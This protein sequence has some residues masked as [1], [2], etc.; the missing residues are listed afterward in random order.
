MKVLRNTLL[1][2]LVAVVANAS[3]VYLTEDVNANDVNV[4]AG[5]PVEKSGDKVVVSG[6]L[7]GKELFATKN[8]SLKIADVNNMGAVKKDG[9]KAKITFAAA[10][11]ILAEDYYDAWEEKEEIFLEK[12]SQ[13]HAAPDIAHH[14]ML[15]WEG[16]FASMKGF[17]QPTEE[18]E[19]VIMQY[20]KTFAKDGIIKEE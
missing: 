15:E 3:T 6:Y 19:V 16:L 2:L 1:S 18:E 12:C 17:A 14:T 10:D 11:D 7:K 13:C 4:I 5:V 20:L 8:L 9:S